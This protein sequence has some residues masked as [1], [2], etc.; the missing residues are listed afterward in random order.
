MLRAGIVYT[1]QPQVVSRL[2]TRGSINES[3]VLSSIKL[4]AVCTIFFF[5]FHS[6]ASFFFTHEIYNESRLVERDYWERGGRGR[7]QRIC[8]ARM[9]NHSSDR[10]SLRT[11]K[12][13]RRLFFERTSRGGCRTALNRSRLYRHDFLADLKRSAFFCASRERE[14]ES[15]CWDFELAL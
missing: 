1:I 8:A 12:T 5:F 15:F 14:G 11:Q 6:R 7:E 9:K 2:I 4:K 13:A 10:E 3:L